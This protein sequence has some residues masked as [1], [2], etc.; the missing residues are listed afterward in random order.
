MGI[1]TGGMR[2]QDEARAASKRIAAQQAKA[3]AGEGKRKKRAGIF[4]KLAGMGLGHVAGMVLAPLTAGL[5]NPLT[6]KL[7]Q[8]AITGGSMWAGRAA[9]HQAST[10]KW[11]KA[12]PGNLK[13]KTAGQVKK[14][15]AGG[16][17]GY[18]R[19]EAKTLSQALA[20]ERKSK[21]DWGT[22]AG[23]IGGSF[24]ASVA[25]DKLS[26]LLGGVPEASTVDLEESLEGWINPATGTQGTLAEYKD[27]AVDRQAGAI[28]DDDFW[29]LGGGV[30]EYAEGG[31]VMDQQQLMA[32][33]ALM[34]QQQEQTAYSGT[35]LEEEQQPSIADMFASKGK[36]L[37]GNNT[38]SLSQML[39]R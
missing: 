7:A 15:E 24:A 18:G 20:D 13:L 28:V 23:D 33:L 16:K 8:A 3:A 6:I 36:T 35:P 17:Y 22:L 2:M 26:D 10:G 12:L 21:E 14:I 9:A 37:G 29:D 30:D 34:S 38:Q 11:D 39:G 1:Y 4:G 31:Q 19:E 27:L 25:G 32:L 5:V